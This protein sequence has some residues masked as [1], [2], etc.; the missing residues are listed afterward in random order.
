MIIHCLYNN[1]INHIFEVVHFILGTDNINE[2]T[3]KWAC[4]VVRNKSVWKKENP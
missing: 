1:L 4:G 2:A 3:L